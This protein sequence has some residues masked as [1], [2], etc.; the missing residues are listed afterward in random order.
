MNPILKAFYNNENEREAVKSF[1]IESL[2]ELAIDK[3]FEGKDTNSIK[4]A[5]ETI[6]KMFDKLDDIYGK[7]E[8]KFISDSR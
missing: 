1:L 3:A 8:E 7:V 5:N 6:L 2:K 4:E